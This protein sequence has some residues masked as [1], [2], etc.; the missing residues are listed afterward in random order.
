MSTLLIHH[1]ACLGHQTPLGHPERADRI[2]V[3]DRILEHE[4]FQPL[5]RLGPRGWHRFDTDALVANTA[6]AVSALAAN[7]DADE[8]S[9]LP[10]SQFELL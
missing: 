3:I 5:E 2:R 9:A 7:I 10:A 1:P 8:Q 6:S 4:R